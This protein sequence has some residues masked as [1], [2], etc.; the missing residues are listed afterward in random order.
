LR[1]CRLR[2][3]TGGATSGPPQGYEYLTL[4]PAADGDVV[5]N[6]GAKYYDRCLPPL[7]KSQLYVH[8]ACHNFFNRQWLN[9]DNGGSLPTMARSDHERVLLTYGCAFFRRALAGHATVGLLVGSELPPATPT[10]L[11]HLSFKW[12]KADTVDDHQQNN[13]IAMNSLNLPTTQSGL[14]A[15]EYGMSQTAANQ[16]N[17]SF[18]GDTIG[19]VAAPR[20]RGAGTFRSRLAPGTKVAGKEVWVRVA[21]VFGGTFPSAATGFSLGVELPNGSVHWVDSDDVGGVPLPFDRGGSTKSM[22]STLRFPAG[23]FDLSKRQQVIRAIVL[24]L[25]RPQ[26]RA[27]AFDDLQII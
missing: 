15:D 24:R 7:F 19:M 11:V 8:N 18:Y 6:D 2:R 27:L 4:L 9:N 25:D 1:C 20:K 22:M 14:T 12:A 10:S 21:D 13:T 26:A 23:C 16:F 3:P 17:G 5:D